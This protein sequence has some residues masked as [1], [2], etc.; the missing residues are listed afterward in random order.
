SGYWWEDR[1]DNQGGPAVLMEGTDTLDAAGRLVVRAPVSTPARGRAGRMAIEAMVTDVNRQSVGA[2]ASVVVH[3]AG[4]YIAAKPSGEY[5]WTG[6]R[7][8][9]IE[10]LAVRP[11]GQRVADVAVSGTIVRREWHQAR[12]DRGGYGEVMGEWVEDTV[13]RCALRTADRPVA[14]QFTPAEGGSYIV[15]FAARDAGGREAVTSFYRWATGR[16]WVPWN[17]GSR[18]KLDIIPDKTRYAPGDTATLLIASPF[19]DAEAWF[20]VEREGIIE[21]RRMR[22]VDGATRI[23]LPITE[24]HAPNVFVSVVVMRGRSGPQGSLDDPGRPAIRVGYAELRVTPEVKR[25]QVTVEPGRADYRPGDSAEVRVSTRSTSGGAQSEVTL[26]AVDE[27]VL[28]LTGYQTPD[29]LDLLYAPRGLGLTLSSDLVNVAPQVLRGES[30]TLKGLTNAGQG[31]G[32]EAGDVLRTRFQTTAFFLGSVVTGAD[33]RATARVKL[34]DNLTTFRVMAVAVT[35]G[36]RYGSGQAPMLVTRPLLAR[37]SLPRFFRPGD[38]FLAGVVVNQRAG[39][40]PTVTVDVTA[41][42]AAL[43]GPP[44]QS[45]TLEA[46]RGREVRFQFTGAPGDSAS[47]R[48]DV[49]GNGDR[50]AVLSRLPVRPAY[51]PRATTVAGVLADTATITMMLPAGTDP[52][53]TR[54]EIEAGVTPFAVLRGLDSELRL[55]DWLCTEQVVSTMSPLLALYRAQELS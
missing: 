9:R 7:P 40:T 21:Q 25:L 23:R 53:R 20:T 30:R 27:G 18:F 12:R 26:W 10:L 28:S 39:G 50:D 22:I 29:P 5:F 43:T 47:F 8:Q 45:A 24:R 3:P 19:T 42:G 13:A 37:P 16:G 33:G 44:R 48:F 41:Q 52:A 36:D 6:G 4:F 55:Y 49:A 38:A 14:C 31:G 15:R 2:I 34:P 54:L 35:A 17:D 1:E 11:N 51:H 32:R 46:G